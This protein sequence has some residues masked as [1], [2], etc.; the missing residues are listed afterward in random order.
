MTARHHQIWLFRHGETEWSLS[1]QHTGRTD[2]PLTAAGRRRA[3]ALARRLSGRP[4]ALILCSPLRRALET[5][6][7]AGYGDVAE[8]DP[9]LMEWDYGDYEGWRTIDIQKERPGW[10]LWRD[11]VPGGETIDQLAARTHHV[12]AAAGSA[13]GDVA[14]FAHGHVLR[15]LT[16]CWLGLPPDAGRLFALGAGA[17]SVLAYEHETHVIVKWNQDSQLVDVGQ[18]MKIQVLAD[19]D[20]VAQAGAEAIAAAA[21]S[22]VATRGR[23]LLALSGGRTPWLMLRAL[24]DQEVPWPKI[25]IFQVDER[26]APAGSP[27]RNLTHLRE[28]LLARVPLPPDNL[29]PM[30]VEESDLAA[31]AASHARTLEAVAGTPPL[32]DLVHLGLGPDGH[33][34]S[35]VPGDSVLEIT[36]AWVGVTGPYQRHRR[37]TL[38]YPVLN[39]AR[40]ILFIVTGEDKADALLR[41]SRHEA[42]IPAGRVENPN[43]LVIADRAA[44]TRLDAAALE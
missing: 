9:D 18:P 3:E 29:H 27:E 4:F 16:A 25:E 17:V 33:T 30:P 2:L 13:E 21:R 22:A 11:G 8:I 40:A 1:G 36:D 35:L 14:L 7:L 23:F 42:S 5:C 31:A 37:M 6:R 24:V 39:R 12:L 32:L 34:A 15:V 38:T 41:L 19:V 44:A 10:S 28:S 43:A 26:I 20:A